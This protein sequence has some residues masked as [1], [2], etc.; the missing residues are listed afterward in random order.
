MPLAVAFPVRTMPV[1]ESA[2]LMRATSRH[3]RPRQHGSVCGTSSLT[4][5]SV[6]R[7]LSCVVVCPQDALR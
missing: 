5:Q 1:P 6:S 4:S 3:G 2:V 7:F